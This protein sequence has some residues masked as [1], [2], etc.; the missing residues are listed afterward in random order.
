MLIAA[1]ILLPTQVQAVFFETGNALVNEMQEDEK[2]IANTGGS[3]FKSGYYVGFIS[4][5]FDLGNT[6]G[7]IC[8]SPSVTV[9]QVTA[10]V[11]KYLKSNPEKWSEPATNL[12]NFALMNAFPC[13]K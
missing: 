9:G 8:S 5:S 12:V 4:A 2:V 10:I 3:Q 1:L 13:K 7:I 6:I 11:T